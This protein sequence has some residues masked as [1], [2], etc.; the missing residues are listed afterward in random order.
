MFHVKIRYIYAVYSKMNIVIQEVINLEDKPTSTQ[1]NLNTLK[2]VLNDFLV[3]LKSEE[4]WN[5]I[6]KASVEI[7]LI[8]IISFLVVKIGN[9]LRE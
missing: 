7:L 6:I 3:Y 4:L 2:N 9:K 8:L 5:F 1:V